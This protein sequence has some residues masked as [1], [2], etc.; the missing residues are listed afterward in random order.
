[1]AY[2]GW[3]TANVPIIL[4][5]PVPDELFSVPHEKVFCLVM[6]ESRLL[7]L[8]QTRASTT[9]LPQG[10][11]ISPEYIRDEILYAKKLCRDRT[12]QLIDTT[13]KSIEEIAREILALM[14]ASEKKSL[15]D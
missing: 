8:R 9:N 5:V 4:E 10:S 11:Y 13:G 1:L 15:P 14:P 2:H 12:W 6:A 3:F 7:E